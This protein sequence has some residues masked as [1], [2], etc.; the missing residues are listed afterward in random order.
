MRG[1]GL[2]Q[3]GG[4]TPCLWAGERKVNMAAPP[5]GP[6]TLGPGRAACGI[7]E[8]TATAV[9]P[10]PEVVRWDY[11]W[12]LKQNTIYRGQAA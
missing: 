2:T 7:G 9:G 4:V 12:E 5:P 11:A 10:A 1:K 6:A 3:G 8:H